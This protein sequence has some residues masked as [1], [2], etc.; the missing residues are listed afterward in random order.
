MAYAHFYDLADWWL[1]PLAS[2]EQKHDLAKRLA[3]ICFNYSKGEYNNADK[4]IEE[5]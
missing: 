4:E 5:V 2:A 3:D 1:G